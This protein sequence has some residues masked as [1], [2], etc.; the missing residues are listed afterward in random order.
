MRNVWFNLPL[1]VTG[2]LVRSAFLSGIVASLLG[3]V[4]LA[5]ETDLPEAKPVP[6]VQ[7]LPLPYD[8]AS[9]TLE[10]SELTRYHFGPALRRPFW[11]PIVGP[12][13]RSLTR[14]GHP[15]DPMGHRHHYSVWITHNDVGGVSFWTDNGPARI[16]CQRVEEYTDGEAEASML[17]VNAWQAEQGKVL[18]LD[19]R[20]ATVR[21]L[22]DRGWMLLI[23]LQLEAPPGKPVTLG[24]TPFG[25]IGVRMAK[26]IGVHDG[27]GRILNSEGQINEKDVFRKPARW[28]DYSGRVTNQATGGIA[29]MDHP[30]NPRHPAPFHVRGDGWMGICLTLEKPLEIEPGRPLRL[31]YALWVHEGVPGRPQV[32]E[33]W[34]AFAASP[35][36]KMEKQRH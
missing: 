26:T 2:A 33:Q 27:G 24:A 7:V 34:Q 11:Y 21:P 35:A 31:R 15:H 5:G 8:Q 12:E 36:P 1:A 13:A 19:R 30:Q 4:V 16:V 17:S 18:M 25:P 29:L 6:A 20:R 23:D 22:G 28:V 10:G 3:A 9:F 32:D 14:M